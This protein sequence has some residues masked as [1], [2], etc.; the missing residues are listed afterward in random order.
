MVQINV[1][2]CDNQSIWVYSEACK[3]IQEPFLELPKAS[4]EKMTLKESS[5]EWV[6][7]QSPILSLCQ[8]KYIW[9]LMRIGINAEKAMMSAKQYVAFPCADFLLGLA[10][11]RKII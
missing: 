11:L 4:D 1:K 3:E 7:S 8:A 6:M 2:W 9:N 10:I 5:P